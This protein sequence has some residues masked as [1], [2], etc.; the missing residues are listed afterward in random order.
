MAYNQNLPADNTADIRENFRALKEDKIVA[1]AT[2]TNLE[3]AR[4]INGVSFDGTANITI[5]QVDGKDIAT[6]DE[7]PSKTNVLYTEITG[8][9]TV[10]SSEYVDIKDFQLVLPPKTNG[11]T[12]ALIILNFASPY[13][14]GTN[15]PGINFGISYNSKMAATGCFTYDQATPQSFGRHPFTLVVRRDLL[16]E[17]DSMVKVQWA[18]V[19]DSV[20]HQGGFASLTAILS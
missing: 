18:N 5:T 15:Y 11:Q 12:G 4:A 16:E 3:T 14:T 20:G 8:D 9:L 13:A 10:S 7:I 17:Q 2:A 19:R 1:A 6:K